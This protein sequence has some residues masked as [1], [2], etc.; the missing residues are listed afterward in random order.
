MRVQMVNS[1]CIENKHLENV[2]GHHIT[3]ARKQVKKP[4][5]LSL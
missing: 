3:R 5:K 2:N 4:N 1:R